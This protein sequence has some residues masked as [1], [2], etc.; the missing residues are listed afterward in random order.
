MVDIMSEVCPVMAWAVLRALTAVG[1][2]RPAMAAP[3]TCRVSIL[4]FSTCSGVRSLYSSFVMN[5]ANPLVYSVILHTS[6]K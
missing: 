6:C 1:S 4:A 5:S 3:A 2:V